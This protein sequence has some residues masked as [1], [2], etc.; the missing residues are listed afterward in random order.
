MLTQIFKKYGISIKQC[1]NEKELSFFCNDVC[2][3]A[4]PTCGDCLQF[5][6]GL[7][8]THHVFTTDII[9]ECHKSHFWYYKIGSVKIFDLSLWKLV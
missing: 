1:L 3:K 7:L 6:S 9:L 5:L 8:L 2:P 4:L